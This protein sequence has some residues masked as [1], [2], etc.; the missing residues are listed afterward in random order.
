MP[1]IS[2]A[3][4]DN[5]EFRLAYGEADNLTFAEEQDDPFGLNGSVSKNDSHALVPADATQSVSQP[6]LS[7]V[8]KRTSTYDPKDDINEFSSDDLHEEDDSDHDH[9][10]EHHGK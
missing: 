6:S 3:L 1:Q 5:E 8:K 7:M 9:V 4:Q 2:R 10:C